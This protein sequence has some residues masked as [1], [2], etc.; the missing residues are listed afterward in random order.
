ME[1][2]A[3]N[4]IRLLPRGDLEAFAIRAA[5]HIR[6]NRMELEASRYFLAVLTGFLLGVLVA[7][8][9]FLVGASLG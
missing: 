2:R 7:T 9:G 1:E 4:T 8:T 6:V 3:V 5:S